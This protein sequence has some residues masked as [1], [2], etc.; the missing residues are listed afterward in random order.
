MKLRCYISARGYIRDLEY[1]SRP[2]RFHQTRGEASDVRRRFRGWVGQGNQPTSLWLGKGDNW[3]GVPR[4]R[5]LRVRHR[6]RHRAI[7]KPVT[8]ADE[9][10]SVITERWRN[11]FKFHVIN[12]GHMTVNLKSG[13][14]REICHRAPTVAV[15]RWLG[16][17]DMDN[18]VGNRL[19]IHQRNQALQYGSGTDALQRKR[20]G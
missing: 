18:N 14:G 4:R 9:S 15:V 16:L 2:Q 10:E 17:V 20:P 8:G 5:T 6:T 19:R 1:P 3:R 12:Q 13:P 7:E 11:R